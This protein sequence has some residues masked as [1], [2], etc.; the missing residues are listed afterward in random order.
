MAVLLCSFRRD[1]S[2]KDASSFFCQ[3]E[4]KSERRCQMRW[5]VYSIGK[6]PSIFIKVFLRCARVDD[7]KI[8]FSGSRSGRRSVGRSAT[9]RWWSRSFQ[10]VFRPAARR[11]PAILSR[12]RSTRA[13]RYLSLTS[14]LNFVHQRARVASELRPKNQRENSTPVGSSLDLQ[15]HMFAPPPPPPST[16]DYSAVSALRNILFSNTEKGSGSVT[17]YRTRD[18]WGAK[19]ALLSWKRLNEIYENCSRRQRRRRPREQCE[20]RR[21]GRYATTDAV[22]VYLVVVVV[23]VVAVAAVRFARKKDLQYKF[24]FGSARCRAACRRRSRTV[25]AP[26]I[27][28]WSPCR[29]RLLIQWRHLTNAVN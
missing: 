11:H 6:C 26:I 1:G 17:V 7:R 4:L 25:G 2:R 18:W 27:H 28:N 22:A 15:I 16:G 5:L 9:R 23:M 24:V 29:A 20:A 19:R 13:Q 12:V 10:Q 3:Q 8:D 21:D 14:L